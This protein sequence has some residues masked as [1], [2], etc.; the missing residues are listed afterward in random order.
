MA[1]ASGVRYFRI[2]LMRWSWK[3]ADLHRD[4]TWGMSDISLSNVTP[5]FRAETVAWTTSVSTLRDVIDDG[6]DLVLLAILMNQSIS[7][8]RSC[9]L[10]MVIRGSFKDRGGDVIHKWFSEN[11]GSYRMSTD[12]NSGLIVR[13]VTQ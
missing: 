9:N 8:R 11:E 1:V 5:R 10:E 3:F 13:W 12:S 6:A 4:C 2:L 7:W